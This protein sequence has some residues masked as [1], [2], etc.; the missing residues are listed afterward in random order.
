M[1]YFHKT[2]RFS[3]YHQRALQF[4]FTHYRGFRRQGRYRQPEGSDRID[5]IITNRC[6][7]S[8]SLPS[9]C[10][11]CI[12]F[13]S[14]R[15]AH[16]KRLGQC[17]TFFGEW[18]P[19]W[20]GGLLESANC[21]PWLESLIQDGVIARRGGRPGLPAADGGAVPVPGY[22]G[23]LRLHGPRGLHHG[24]HFPQIPAFPGSPSS[25]CSFPWVSGVPGIMATRTI[26]NEKD[27]RMTI[28]TTTFIPC[29]AKTPII[30][31]IAGAFFPENSL[32][33]PGAYFIGWAPSSFPASF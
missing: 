14:R 32:G 1:I 17:D 27:R 2:I 3:V 7:A 6:W 22:S 12:T 15:R 19:E 5:R 30:A 10:G 13:P 25:P 28:M 16:G 31:L 29:G 20:V 23:R 21:A 8:P 18:V 33:G 11:R 26:E 24:P 4:H 9:S